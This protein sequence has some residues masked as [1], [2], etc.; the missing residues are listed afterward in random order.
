MRV[1]M[2]MGGGGVLRAC[3][4]MVCS[5][6]CVYRGMCVVY[7]CACVLTGVSG[8]M[9]MYGYARGCMY[10]CGRGYGGMG[11]ARVCTCVVV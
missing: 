4:D 2:L 3:V 10:V 5:Y 7:V 6:V 9:C 1:C 11:G 8:Y